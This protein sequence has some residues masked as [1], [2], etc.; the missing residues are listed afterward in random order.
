[1]NW[2]RGKFGRESAEEAEMKELAKYIKDPKLF[3]EYAK[4]RNDPENMEYQ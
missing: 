2:L 3:E 1:M 4:M